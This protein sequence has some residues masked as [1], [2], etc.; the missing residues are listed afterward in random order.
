MTSPSVRTRKVILDAA[1]EEFA[2]HGLAG[3]R[4]ERIAKA[5]GANVQRIYAY[6]SDK[7]GLF[8]AV[9]LDAAASLA[10]AIRTE[11]RDIDSLA[12]AIFDFVVNDP[13]NTRTM[14]WA[15]LERED[16]FFQLMDTGQSGVGAVSELAR[17]QDAGLVTTDWDAVTILEALIAL[18]EQ[19][20]PN[21]RENGR[22]D[23]DRHRALVLRFVRTLAVEPAAS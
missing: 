22:S 5:A 17:L 23:I 12:N 10:E 11:H 2:A 18:C 20:H 14:T 13:A 16:E 7:Q 19:W 6:Y 21:T 3:G 8:D 1:R 9:V 15:R 4:V